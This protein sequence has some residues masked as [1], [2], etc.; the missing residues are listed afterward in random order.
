MEKGR[1]PCHARSGVSDF[2]DVSVTAMGA[3]IYRLT[4]DALV[5][6]RAQPRLQNKASDPS[7]RRNRGVEQLFRAHRG[8]CCRSRSSREAR[9]QDLEQ[10][11]CGLKRGRLHPITTHVRVTYSAVCRHRARLLLL[12]HAAVSHADA[13]TQSLKPFGGSTTTTQEELELAEGE[14]RGGGGLC[15]R[16]ALRRVRRGA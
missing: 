11:S 4:G 3:E 12:A 2:V 16:R 10:K 6:P 14:S 13:I 9:A 7:A 8:T 5:M 15:V 1:A